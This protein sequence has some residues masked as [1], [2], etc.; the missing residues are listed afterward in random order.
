MKLKDKRLKIYEVDGHYLEYLCSFDKNVRLKS[1]RKYTGILVSDNDVDYCIPLTSKVKKRSPKLT[2]NIKDKERTISQ[3]TINNMI[4]V[5][6]NVV[7][8]VDISH[9][10][11]SDYLNKEI[12]FLRKK[13]N[14]N[15]LIAKT[16]NVFKV[17]NNPNDKDYIFF[18]RLC[19]DYSLLEEK[20]KEY[21]QKQYDNIENQ[22]IEE[23][24]FEVTI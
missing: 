5:N 23:E 12:V 2:V 7:H 11:H 15:S 24:E 14:I 3:L 21:I 18:K 13:H 8:M 4:P 22:L 9:E 10:K 19:A 20:C 17:L 16:E 6:E 1:D